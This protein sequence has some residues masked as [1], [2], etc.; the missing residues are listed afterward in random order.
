M[1]SHSSRRQAL[2]K[3]GVRGTQFAQLTAFVAV[4]EHRSFTK[5]AEYLGLSTPSLSQAIRGLEE[6]FGVRLLN[7]TTRSVALTEAGEQLLQHLNP[8]LEGVDNAID[9]VNAYRDTPGG[10]LRLTVHPLAAVTVLAPLVARFSSEYPSIELEVSVDSA[11]RDIVAEHFDAGVHLSSNIAQDM[12]AVPIGGNFRIVTVASP[13]YLSRS[14]GLVSPSDLGLH[15]CVRYRWDKAVAN[16]WRY[17]KDGARVDV[18]VEGTLA[19]ND[20]ELAL[21][22]ALDGVGVVQLPEASVARLIAEGRL[23][24]LLAEWSA[25]WGSF[26]LFYPSR[27]H[28]P[29][30]MRSLVDFLRREAKATRGK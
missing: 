23:V 17:M 16:T 5:A 28:V 27:R 15:N 26:F 19:V 11:C 18:A 12:I 21:R 8:V 29:M 2:R 14:A 30:K 7:R 20:H 4:A 22:S 9:A 25:N 24:P 6:T 10:T 3:G 13:E 1:S